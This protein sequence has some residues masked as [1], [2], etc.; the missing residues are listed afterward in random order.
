MLLPLPAGHALWLGQGL[1]R[2]LPAMWWWLLRL[3]QLGQAQAC[4]FTPKTTF[5]GLPQ[6]V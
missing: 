2:A 4:K 1:L 5:V 6:M 3:G